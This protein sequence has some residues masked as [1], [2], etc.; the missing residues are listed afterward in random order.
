MKVAVSPWFMRSL[1]RS[2]IIAWKVAGEF[3]NPKYMTVGSYA[4]M[5]VINAAFHSSPSLILTLLY[6]YLK[7]NF[8]NTFL[9]PTLSNI[10]AMRGKGYPFFTIH[11][12][13]C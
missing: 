10:S 13:M 8:I 11:W 7:S 9:F 2:F 6:P 5:C 4:P 3:V 12:F 1:N